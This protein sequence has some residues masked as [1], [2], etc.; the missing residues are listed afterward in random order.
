M[1]SVQSEIPPEEMMR[2]A[3]GASIF[4]AVVLVG[5]KGG[6]VWYT[7]S[8]AVSGS[9][10]DSAMDLV[11]SALTMVAILTSIRPP[12]EE[13]RFGHGKAEGIAGLAQA[14]LVS[15][16]AL[17]LGGAS[18]LRLTNPVPVEQVGIGVAII[19][20][21]VVLTLAL[22]WYQRKVVVATGS[23]SVAA[24]SLHYTSDLVMNIGVLVALGAS[25]I[26]G[27]HLA[28]PVCGA[29]VAVWVLRSAM[30]IGSQ[31]LD[32][33]LDR[34]LSNA[35]RENILAWVG[36][37]SEVKGVHDLRTR[38][39]GRTPIIQFHMELDA[40]MSLGCAHRIT[41]EVEALIM[42]QLSNAQVLIHLDPDDLPPDEPD[43]ST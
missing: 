41:E 14:L 19:S 35:L 24:D 18:L 3:G 40:Q 5:L 10:V 16:S 42:A 26:L 21:S 4:T 1:P 15:L 29:L 11:A 20:M 32:V 25:T 30:N 22:V 17:A 23:L 28:D 39:S 34:E 38:Q 31:S 43:F 37:P 7:G 12:D 6:A 33:L 2:R 27:W 8:L 9:L 13:H 36:S